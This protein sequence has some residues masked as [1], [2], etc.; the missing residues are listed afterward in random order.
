[1][2]L[3]LTGESAQPGRPLEGPGARGTYPICF[4]QYGFSFAMLHLALNASPFASNLRLMQSVFPPRGPNHGRPGRI[5]LL[6]LLLLAAI[7]GVVL[8]STLLLMSK[9][10]TAV[11]AQSLTFYC[12]AGLRM[13]VEEIAAQFEKEYGITIQTDFQGSN[14]L[15]N[16][17]TVNKLS[18]PDLYLA[19]DDFYTDKAVADGL[20]AETMK[21][22]YQRPVIA[23]PKGNPKNIASIDDLLRD[24]V[25]VVMANPDQAAVG[26]ATL[27]ALSQV[28]RPEGNLW[29]QLEAHV[30]RHGVFKPTVN[31]VATDIAHGSVDA[32][33]VWNSTVAM[34]NYADDL[35]AIEV[36]EFA[37]A[38]DLI[39]VAVLTSSRK[40]T[41]ALKFA[42]YLT[43][44]DKGLPI[45]AKYGTDPVEG[46]LWAER[47]QVTF[48][49]GAVNRRAVEQAVAEFEKREDVEV[50]TVFDGCGILT[51]R[52]KTIADQSTAAGFPDIYMACDVYYL[53]NVRPWFQNAVNV[54][55]A[56]IVLA[57]PAGSTQV[58]KLAD[59]IEPGVR[60]AIGQADQCTIGA[61][62]RRLLEH[63][64]LYEP[65][66]KK[67][68][69]EGEVVVE[70]PSSA[71][72]V[73]DVL[74]GHVDVAVAYLTDIGPNADQLDVIRIDSPLNQAIQPLSIARSSQYKHLTGRLYQR[75]ARSREAFEAAGFHYR[76]DTGLPIQQ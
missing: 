11:D 29:Q 2:R 66:R 73:P 25:F 17:L 52:M 30:T 51:G 13:P 64:N 35:E 49:C 58:T 31:E 48:Y 15:L 7:T 65:L 21:I 43:A 67:Q 56:E 33:I 42:R 10:E 34:P 14:T 28:N 36:A 44:R 19:A 18:T 68:R 59:L 72:L 45:F 41:A 23:V 5:N 63:E 32:G 55:D 70:K 24:D 60:V 47:P 1:M 20:A 40:P 38:N 8:L 3:I 62:T 74:T 4:S 27:T 16:Q 57:V 75:I 39:S 9:P 46:D 54:S 22:A 61:L 53:D 37:S 76:L 12:A 69:Q 26:K 50:N 6:W 71:M